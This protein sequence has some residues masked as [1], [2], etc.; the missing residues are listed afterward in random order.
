MPDVDIGIFHY[1]T[2]LYLLR[3]SVSSWIQSSLIGWFDGPVSSRDPFVSTFPPTLGLQACATMS[4]GHMGPHAFVAGTSQAEQTAQPHH[5]SSFKLALFLLCKA[6]FLIVQNCEWDFSTW[7]VFYHWP[8]PNVCVNRWT[9]H[10]GSP[11]AHPAICAV[12]FGSFCFLFLS[13][14]LFCC[15]IFRSNY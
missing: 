3:W 7:G 14:C 11:T 2:L 9:I 13:L 12:K 1:H 4:S 15:F 6:Y 10:S 5:T 8:C